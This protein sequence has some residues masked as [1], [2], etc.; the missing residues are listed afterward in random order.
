VKVV[1]PWKFAVTAA[2]TPP[3]RAFGIKPE[4]FAAALERPIFQRDTW[5]LGWR[6]S[7]QVGSVEGAFT[8]PRSALAFP[9]GSPN[10]LSGCDAESS[11]VSSLRYA[12]GELHLAHRITKLRGLT[13]HVAGGINYIDGAFQVN[14]VSRG[15]LDRTKL[16]TRGKT[17]SVSAGA[18]YPLTQ[19]IALAIDVFYSPLWVKRNIDAPVTNDGLFNV[20]ALLTY[21][22]R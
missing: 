15:R 3:I 11:D 21:R 16:L 19:R 8:C 20:R 9:P 14:S 10:N 13:P 18:A 12:G 2:V 5:S 1:L 22:L 6:L 4:L 17:F 7:G